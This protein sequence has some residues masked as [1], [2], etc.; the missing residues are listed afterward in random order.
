METLKIHIDESIYDDVLSYLMALPRDKVKIV[1]EEK[2]FKANRQYLQ[3]ELNE[4]DSGYGRFIELKE[5][6][7]KLEKII[8]NYEDN[9]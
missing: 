7:A 9:N 1:S 5:L 4:I 2:Q 6:E 8:S 3:K